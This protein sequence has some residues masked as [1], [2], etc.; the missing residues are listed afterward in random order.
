MP[1]FDD[2]RW[3]FPPA[4]KWPDDDVVAVGADL[5]TDTLLHA[6]SHGMFPMHID[7]MK[8]T[9][10]WWSPVARGIIPLDGLRVSR[11]MRR[12]ARSFRVT[13]DAEFRR[14]VELCGTTHRDGNWITDAFVQAYGRLHDIG[15]ATSVEVRDADG[16]IVGGL[17]GVRIDRFFAG[18]SMFHLRTD[19]SKVA[20]MHLVDRLRA[21]GC[22]LLDTQ[23]CT[24]HLA[25]LGCIEVPRADY[26][27]M[28]ASA[29]D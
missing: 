15:H 11:S 22:T 25:S 2:C 26:L 6:Y 23:W 10:G 28:L 7:R 14:V 17:Y 5:E 27:G 3:K 24:T 29:L 20:M 12:S 19:A 4:E 18:E 13:F 8:E 9:L 1:R 16:Q 21:E